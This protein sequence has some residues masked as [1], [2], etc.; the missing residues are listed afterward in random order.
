MRTGGFSVFL[1]FL[2]LASCQTGEKRRKKASHHHALAVSLMSECS[3]RRALSHL[4]KA[5]ALNPQSFLARHTLASVYFVLG[6]HDLAVREFS[7]ILKMKP[8]F[9]EARVNLAKIYID[10]GRPGQALEEMKRAERDL[11]YASRWKIISQKGQAYFKRGE[12]LKARRQFAEAASIPPAKNCFN[13]VYLGRAEMAL[14]QLERAEKTLTQALPLCQREPA[15]LCREKLYQ[16]HFFLGLLYVKKR[17]KRKASYHL[18]IFLKR[19]A[20]GNPYIPQAKK[21]LE[22]LSES[23]KSGARARLRPRMEPAQRAAGRMRGRK[24]ADNH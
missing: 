14:N 22:S 12:F 18:N 17:N 24:G 1:G 13:T 2:F 4:L 19:A 20:R 8:G 7:K 11:T 21:L 5:A 3:S 6:R 10:T 9:T 16:E 15:P 23:K